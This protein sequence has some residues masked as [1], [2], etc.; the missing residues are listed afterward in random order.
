M[1]F[2]ILTLTLIL[3]FPTPAYSASIHKC[4]INTKTTYQDTP[5]P[6]NESEKGLSRLF[7]NSIEP[8]AKTHKEYRARRKYKDAVQKEKSNRD[9]ENDAI[10]R[11]KATALTNPD[12]NSQSI[13]EMRRTRSKS[14]AARKLLEMQYPAAARETEI[15]RLENKLN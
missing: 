10:K 5:C 6:T 9:T 4:V 3:I 1:P 12:M 11:L 8:D 2:L 14:N 7:F 15:Q 13:P